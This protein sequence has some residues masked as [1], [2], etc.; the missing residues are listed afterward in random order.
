MIRS[1][2][3]LAVLLAMIAGSLPAV[4]S[5]VIPATAALVANPPVLQRQS[6]GVREFHLDNGL[7]I[8]LLN[9]A[10]AEKTLVNLSY[11]VGSRHD[12]RTQP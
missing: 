4:A 5:P 11:H 6:E 9:D 8:L 3:P 12:D 10:S 2:I 1:S 7:R